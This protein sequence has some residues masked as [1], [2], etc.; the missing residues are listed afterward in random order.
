MNKVRVLV[1]TKKIKHNQSELKNT[2]IKI[3]NTLE[4][5]KNILSDTEKCILIG[6]IK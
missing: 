5:I 6:K 3:K 2:I 1:V 4:G